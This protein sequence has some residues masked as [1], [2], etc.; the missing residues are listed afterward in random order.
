[1]SGFDKIFGLIA[2]FVIALAG[3][4]IYESMFADAGE[5]DAF[6]DAARLV[7]EKDADRPAPRRSQAPS[8]VAKPSTRRNESV[9]ADKVRTP[10]RIPELP[11]GSGQIIGTVFRYADADEEDAD[12][13]NPAGIETVG[14]VVDNGVPSD[15]ND[16]NGK[17]RIPVA[18]VELTCKLHFP[19]G[20]T[21]YG[22]VDEFEIK[23]ESDDEGRFLLE[24]P[25]HGAYRVETRHDDYA[26][27][28]VEAARGGESVDIELGPGARFLGHVVV[29]G[30][31]RTVPGARITLRHA[32]R[33][34]KRQET[35]DGDGKFNLAGLFAGRYFLTVD[36]PDYMPVREIETELDLSEPEPRTIELAF[37]KRIVG[38]V[39]D[40]K[41][42]PVA[43]AL[44]SSETS[45]NLP[46]EASTD[47]IGRFELRGLTI[48]RH[49]IK[50]V[51]DGYLT[52]TQ[53]VN[54]SGS[55]DEATV[56]VTLSEGG[57][58]EG[59]ILDD[60]G[61]ALADVDIQ[62]FES[63]TWNWS[64]NRFDDSIGNSHLY[65]SNNKRYAGTT[66]QDGRYRMTGLQFNS[67]R[68]YR[69]R[70]STEGYADT[71][72][73][74]VK[75][76]RSGNT[77]VRKTI[78]LIMTE[79]G[80][81][82]GSVRDDF[83]GS[84]IGA[85]VV[86]RPQQLYEGRNARGVQKAVTDD[87]GQFRFAGLATQKYT[88]SAVA[89]G[90]AN[91]AKNGIEIS[92]AQI[93]EGIELSLTK[94]Q[95]V[96]GKVTSEE[97]DRP[98]AGA[99]ISLSSDRT[100]A[101][102]VTKE[103]GTYSIDS[104]GEGPYNVWV[105]ATGYATDRRRRVSPVDGELD[106]ELSNRGY[107]EGRIVD[108]ESDKAVRTFTVALKAQGSGG[109]GRGRTYRRTFRDADGRF[110]LH[111]NDGTYVMTVS[112][113]GYM[114]K[115]VGTVSISAA[116]SGSEEDERVIRLQP[117][118]ALEGWV[119]DEFGKPQRGVTIYVRDNAASE[120]FAQRGTTEADG[121]F[122]VDS[123]R[124]GSF[125]VVAVRRSRSGI[126]LNSNISILRGEIY[127]LRTILA[128]TPTVHVSAVDAKEK[129]LRRTRF[130]VRQ[131][132]GSPFTLQ[133]HSWKDRRSYYRLASEKTYSLRRGKL[134]IRDLASGDYV[135]EVRERNA[136][137]FESPIRDF[138]V[139]GDDVY[140]DF[141]HKPKKK[142]GE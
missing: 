65:G 134:A 12:E 96:H 115:E 38:R 126:V 16:E 55:R 77:P 102:A 2:I 81:V 58:I 21:N 74:T 140:L 26:P 91:A 75:L 114:T 53:P 80:V 112:A 73:R 68:G 32:E 99:R 95:N 14:A 61:R 97:D 60:A 35:T 117:G 89:P 93:V 39:I 131:A 13:E 63:Y 79:G 5:I 127:Q 138:L 52:K 43:D 123:L 56:E 36:H 118:G 57:I 45:G 44:V 76:R 84:V 119:A 59:T 66:D 31:A 34:W 28:V 139:D 54:M 87:E 25:G 109:R 122:F 46:R 132:D 78:D 133:Y 8:R 130:L 33:A 83:G 50:V 70:A 129:P 90:Y 4:A 110:R 7:T 9:P 105:N 41:G 120:L 111:A 71:Y 22:L 62:V 121:Y 17:S 19:P 128:A 6:D 67:W 141:R 20:E 125:D 3:W 51:A 11:E 18:G 42:T 82:T 86:I 37:G 88:V 72:S 108:T 10:S 135:I 107:V 104:I 29:E 49:R 113:K 30:G 48:D 136:K 98:I 142:R 100:W 124:E 137:R 23:V 101:S 92:G 24:V 94:G 15:E 85:K 103:D 116:S 1:M 106:F 69:V 64:Y 27:T 47:D 40:K